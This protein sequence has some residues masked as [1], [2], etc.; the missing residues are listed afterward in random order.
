ML[1]DK[2]VDKFLDI[3]N[4]FFLDIGCGVG[5]LSSDDPAFYSNTYALESRKWSGIGID[6][7]EKYWYRIGPKRKAKILCVDLLSEN[8]NKILEDNECPI[9]IDYLSLD[10]DD[11][12]EKV[13]NELSFDKYRFKVMTIETNL[14]QNTGKVISNTIQQ[15]SLLLNLGYKFIARNVKLKNYGIVEDWYYDSTQ[16]QT[17]QFFDNEDCEF[18]AN[19][20][21]VIKK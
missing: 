12:Q 19:N 8:I 4:G 13:F 5:G 14:F 18:I 10:V 11:A 7:D 2:F 16:I 20:I 6:F 21:K 3:D 9:D 17:D 15:R 1:Q